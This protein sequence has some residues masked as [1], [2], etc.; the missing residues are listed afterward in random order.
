MNLY[1]EL[2]NLA[3]IELDEAEQLLLT[4]GIAEL[5]RQYPI[6]SDRKSVV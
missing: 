6:I 1:E 5:K 3:G 4:E 2:L